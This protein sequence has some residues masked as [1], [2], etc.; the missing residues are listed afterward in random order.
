M[1]NPNACELNILDCLET[2][3][4]KTA[5]KEILASIGPGLGNADQ[6]RA[7]FVSI[8][9]GIIQTMINMRLSKSAKKKIIAGLEFGRRY[10]IYRHRQ[11]ITE[12]PRSVSSDFAR[13][14]LKKI[15]PIMRNHTKEWLG[16]VT[17]FRNGSLSEF[18]LAEQGVRTHVNIEPAELFA[19]ILMLRPAGFFLFHNHPSGDITPSAQDIDMTMRIADVSE[20]LGVKFPGHWIISPEHEFFIPQL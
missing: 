3:V 10:A 15:S 11:T 4:G 5:I 16:F 14:A 13:H 12:A 7:L 2:L 20:Q 1:L 19:R 9:T 8:E 6:E 17:F 18:C